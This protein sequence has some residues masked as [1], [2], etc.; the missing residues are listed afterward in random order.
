MNKP[1]INKHA[2][3]CSSALPRSMISRRISARRRSRRRSAAC[4]AAEPVAPDCRLARR[5]PR[6]ARAAC[7][8]PRRRCR[9]RRRRSTATLLAENGL[10]V[11]GA[12][13]GVL[14]E[15]FRL[16]KRQLLLTARRLARAA[17]DQG[18]HDPG[19]LGPAG[20]RQDLLRGQP[21]HLDGG[22]ARSRV[23]LVDADFAKPGVMNAARRA[24]TAPACS[25]RSPIPRSTS[26]RCVVAHRHSAI[27]ACCRRAPGRPPTPSCSPAS[28]RPS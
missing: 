24:T 1:I 17:A 21:R 19:L 14:A 20:R 11:P 3:R 15:E 22:R 9:P 13:I 16:V 10:L 27:S 8:T 28:A 25:T 18:A 5:Q 2:A 12:P 7:A 23:L 6:R 26:R 4:A